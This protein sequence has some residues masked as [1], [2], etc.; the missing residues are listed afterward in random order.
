MS[1]GT[2]IEWTRGDDGSPG[3]T[4]NPVSGCDRISPGC[5][6]CYALAMAKRLQAMGA[7]KYQTDGHPVTSGPGFGVAVHEAALPEPLRWRKP[8]RV[9]VGSMTDAAHA[10]VPRGFL[11]RM[12][13]VMA[14]APQH[15]FQVRRFGGP[16]L[17]DVPDSGVASSRVPGHLVPAIPRIRC[18]ARTHG[19]STGPRNLVP[20][21]G[22]QDGDEHAAEALAEEVNQPPKTASRVDENL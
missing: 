11:A 9:F 21:V 1:G 17:R 6:N 5:R 15:T 12:F 14:P 16:V 18:T 8:R 10:R 7:A 22:P 2:A 20:H 4:W 13:A 19:A 3:A